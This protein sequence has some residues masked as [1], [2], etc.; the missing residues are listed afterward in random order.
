MGTGRC[1]GGRYSGGRYGGGHYSESFQKEVDATT[2]PPDPHIT[3][4]HGRLQRKYDWV[5]LYFF[6]KAITYFVILFPSHTN[7][8]EKVQ[9]RYNSLKKLKFSKFQ[10]EIDE[11]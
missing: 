6:W 5:V 10:I 2:E 3:H 1:G 4:N 11:N 9:N 8:L 7:S